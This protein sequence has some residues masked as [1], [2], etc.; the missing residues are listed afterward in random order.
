MTDEMNGAE[1]IPE[2]HPASPRVATLSI[3]STDAHG[4]SPDGK[5][6]AVL[7]TSETGQKV[8]LHLGSVEIAADFELGVTAAH[9]MARQAAR[10]VLGDDST[11]ARPVVNFSVG[12]V[13]GVPGV[14]LI[15]NPDTPYEAVFAVPAAIAARLAELTA[16]E[17]E[18][19]LK[20]DKAIGAAAPGQLIKP[21][22]RI[23]KP[24]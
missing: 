22:R 15:M 5:S 1:P 21:D 6:A 12:H 8:R 13:S 20:I 4:A 7:V 23:H 18:K 10:K 24:N 3:A 11:C 16:S 2:G 19:R 17:A 14:L 9:N